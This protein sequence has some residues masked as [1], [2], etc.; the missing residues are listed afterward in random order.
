MLFVVC[1]NLPEEK[2]GGGGGEDKVEEEAEEEK[3]KEEV[4]SPLRSM[5]SH[6][7]WREKK[8]RKNTAKTVLI[9]TT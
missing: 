7:S 6:F 3:E 5:F 1:L 9:K 4:N 2:E 8:E